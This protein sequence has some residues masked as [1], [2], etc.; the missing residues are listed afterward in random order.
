M[1]GVDYRFHKQWLARVHVAQLEDIY[2]QQVF[3]L[4]NKSPGARGR[5]AAICA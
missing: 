1:A 2:R 3:T 4:V 5:S